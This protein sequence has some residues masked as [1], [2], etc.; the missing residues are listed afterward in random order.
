VGRKR[1]LDPFSQFLL[2]KIER[3]LFVIVQRD[4]Q[5]LLN[6]RWVQLNPDGFQVHSFSPSMKEW[7]YF[8]KIAK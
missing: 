1:L 6:V 2:D 3:A 4:H 7:Q 8:I 5:N